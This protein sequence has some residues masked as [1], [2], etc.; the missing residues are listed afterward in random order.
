MVSVGGS[1]LIQYHFNERKAGQAAATLLREAGG[2]L[3]YMVL[4][5]L[6]YLADR[7]C[8]AESGCPI[9]GDRYVS[10]AKGPVLSQVLDLISEGPHPDRPSPWFDFVSAPEGYDV[11][12][13]RDFA[14]DEF[15]ELSDYETSL[16]RRAWDDFGGIPKWD[17]IE[18][19]HKTLPE[20]EDPGGSVR[21]IR[22]EDILRAVGKTDD[23]IREIE[24]DRAA[25]VLDRLISKKP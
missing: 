12:L 4:I 2:K 18:V 10:M 14:D 8:L 23:E 6:L 20:W 9:T 1:C 3:P 21:P 25:S 13:V 5:K 15:G 7:A 17:L 19:L 11:T 24:A 22:P 16:L